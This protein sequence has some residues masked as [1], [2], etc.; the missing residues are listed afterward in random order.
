M[1][2]EHYLKGTGG[3]VPDGSAGVGL[4]RVRLDPTNH[5]AY[6]DVHYKEGKRTHVCGGRYGKVAGL[7]VADAT[8]PEHQANPQRYRWQR[9]CDGEV[10]Q[11]E[12]CEGKRHFDCGGF[13]AFCY[14]RA[15]PNV[16]Y[17][18]FASTVMT[19]TFGWNPVPKEQ[20]EPG[21]IAST[22]GGGHVGICIDKTT[23]ISALGKRWGVEYDK[24]SYTKFGRLA[25]LVDGAVA[26]GK[27]AEVRA[28]GVVGGTALRHS[29][30]KVAT[31]Q[32]SVEYKG[33]SPELQVAGREKLDPPTAV[34]L[35]LQDQADEIVRAEQFYR[36]D[37]RAIAGAIAWE[38]LMNPPSL[39]RRLFGRA[40]LVAGKPHVREHYL[41]IEGEPVAKQVEEA[42]YLPR[43]TLAGR[44]RAVATPAGAI[45]YIA[46]IM[47]AFADATA[48]TRYYTA[49][50][51]YGLRRRD[52]RC[53]PSLLTYVYQGVKDEGRELK[54]WVE[55]LNA[56][57][58]KTPLDLANDMPNWL[59][60][61]L[62][63]IEAAV[64]TPQLPESCRDPGP[65]SPE[66]Q[67]R[68]GTPKRR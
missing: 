11:G 52:P 43:Q 60:Q 15:C 36:V 4:R 63:F 61:H 62:W 56:K 37:R 45:K 30:S 16:K 27:A 21:D 18:G 17:P 14:S 7:P 33:L 65:S 28:G 20:V 58:V 26:P 1:A 2:E 9:V 31:Q 19:S 5:G 42:G 34:F 25:C 53:D 68:T 57:E 10:V 13:V 6:V 66:I 59:R 39:L 38:A 12:A 51:R 41:P 54:W 48:T 8:N 23:V 47:A 67:R 3:E 22:S 55:H 64:G 35:W 50:S 29:Q 46:G 40:P 32:L 24:E 49:A 44:K